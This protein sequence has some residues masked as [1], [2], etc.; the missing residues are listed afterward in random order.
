MPVPAVEVRKPAAPPEWLLRP[1]RPSDGVVL[2][3]RL[4]RENTHTLGETLG[5]GALA[6]AAFMVLI[7]T[8]PPAVGLMIVLATLCGAVL[9]YK[10]WFGM[11]K[12]SMRAAV[13]LTA[14]ASNVGWT[15][16]LVIGTKLS[17]F[18]AGVLALGAS[19]VAMRLAAD[20]KVKRADERW[21]S[22]AR[23]SEALVLSGALKLVSLPDGEKQ[24]PTLGFEGQPRRDDV[25]EWVTV[26][27][28]KGSTYAQV[29]KVH[30]QLASAMEVDPELLHLEHPRGKA[31]SVMTIAVLKQR[32]DTVDT[33]VLPERT[34]FR[35]AVQLGKD[36]LGRLCS[37]A[38][39][40]THSAFIGKTRSG[41]TWL[42]RLFVA[43]ALLD[44]KVP[45]W[46]VSGKD[47]VEDWQ[48]M[49]KLAVGYATVSDLRDVLRVL[50][51]VEA[52]ADARGGIPKALRYPAVLIV[53][54]WYRLIGIAEQA[55]PALA[56]ELRKL[57]STLAATLASRRVHLVM[58]FQR[59]T[60][61]FI[62]S[63]LRASLGQKAVGMTVK[64]SEV[65]IVLD[66][67]DPQVLPRE[68][69]EFLITMDDSEPTL[70]QV[71]MLDDA[72]FEA[73]CARAQRLRAAEPLDLAAL[74]PQQ[75][76]QAPQVTQLRAVPA[77]PFGEA[78]REALR[79][80]PLSATELR[81]ALPVELRPTSA[82]QTGVRAGA[83]QGVDKVWKA[84]KVGGKQNLRAY[85]LADLRDG[86][87]TAGEEPAVRAVSGA[88]H[89]HYSSAGELP[90][91]AAGQP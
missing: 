27:L 45:V 70:V 35:L 12:V 3:V 7:A 21:W 4:L 2:A 75:V 36:R 56:R 37:L 33:P 9:L 49:R 86:V 76:P 18:L 67:M 23:L 25:G 82:A 40:D 43:Y 74:I 31:P 78:V 57:M 48:A 30:E 29:R 6:V 17:T 38:T 34:D 58:T 52:F 44:P 63:D 51:E 8:Y 59:G 39:L 19:E 84:G 69:G 62:G 68:Q 32:G 54:E 60:D 90:A 64:N 10:A 85:A 72:A 79:G 80:G 66:D 41:K 89:A 15:L 50:R 65:R 22:H 42:A 5:W 28:P 83:V 11:A 1:L 47:D 71:P 87:A 81:A 13:V 24:L 73:I 61:S 16:L 77:D 53:D 26:K 91:A 14:V 20:P 46:M 88:T 55:D